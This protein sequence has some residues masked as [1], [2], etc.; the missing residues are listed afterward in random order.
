MEEYVRKDYGR[1]DE[2]VS[3][4]ASRTFKEKGVRG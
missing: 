4:Q 3:H 2:L 1:W